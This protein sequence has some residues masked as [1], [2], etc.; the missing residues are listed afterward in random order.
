[1]Q[2]DK[3]HLDFDLGFLDG[4]KSREAENAPSGTSRGVGTSTSH[5]K[6]G[7][8]INWRNIAIIGALIAGLAVW[9]NLDST[10]PA[11]RQSPTAPVASQSTYQHR[12]T[13][14]GGAMRDGHFR[15]SQYYNDKAGRLAPK[16]KAELTYEQRELY[17]RRNSLARLKAQIQGSAVNQYSDQS[18]IN[19]YNA[20]VDRYNAQ[21]TS[22]RTEAATYHANVDRF[23]AQV[24]AYNNY[25]QAHCRS[26]E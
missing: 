17:Q 5:V 15:C 16:N 26:G 18:A 21:L 11:S 10:P 6:S 20:L 19:R 7:Y 25:L 8:K 4:A 2:S 14:T 9:A 22:F 12:A 23:N 3:K 13:N 1:M 24:Q